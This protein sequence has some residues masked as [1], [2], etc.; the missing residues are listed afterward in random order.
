MN[1]NMTMNMDRRM[2]LACAALA[3]AA[4]GASGAARA[5]DNNWIDAHDP[6][7]MAPKTEH[8]V[9]SAA[10]GVAAAALVDN[11]AE[12]FA[13]AMAPGVAKELYD[14]SRGGKFNWADIGRD[15]VGAYVG[16]QLGG[17]AFSKNRVTYST[18]F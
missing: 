16:V 12:A 5:G 4:I 3:L 8:V 2:K 15:A 7:W 11:K 13:L 10:F 18:S 14:R 9:F 1:M 17:W 6:R